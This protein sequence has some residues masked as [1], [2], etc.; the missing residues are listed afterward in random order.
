MILD[1]A[2]PPL[3]VLLVAG[4][5]LLGRRFAWPRADADGAAP[6]APPVWTDAAIASL[7]VA[8][9]ATLLLAMGRPLVYRNGP[10]R[11]WSGDVQSDQNSQQLADP[12]TLTHVTHGILLFGLVGPVCRRLPART[13]VVVALALECAWEVLENTEAVIQRYR[14]ATV[15]LG[16]HGDSVLNSVGDVL[17]AALGCVLAM[18]LPAWLLVVGIVLLEGILAVWIRDNLTLNV[19]MLLSPVE[20]I[21]RWQGGG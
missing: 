19:L 6:P 18:W 9:T 14:A 5:L 7:L 21:R 12:Y 13:R 8:L 2:L 20:A 10:V 4:L 17:A 3:L 1:G 16:Y 15:S 11:L